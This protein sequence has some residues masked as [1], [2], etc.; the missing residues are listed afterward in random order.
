MRRTARRVGLAAGGLAAVLAAAPAAAQEAAVTPVPPRVA[1]VVGNADYATVSDLPNAARDA[2]DMAALLRLFGFEVFEGRDLDRRGF[3]TFLRE[4]LLNLPEGAEVVFFYAGH[5]I[6]IGARNYLLPTD[7]A[8]AS[9]NDLPLYS[10]TLDRVVEAL[11]ARGSVHVVFVDACRSNPFPGLS[12][13]TGLAADIAETRSGF[14][15]FPAPINSL[16]AFSTSP[17]QTA[18]DGPAGQNS[19]YTAALLAAV[20]AAPQDDVASL[21]PRI[22]EQVYAATGGAQVPWESSTLV[23][24]FQ[25]A[26][27]GMTALP[28]LV[29][30]DVP[31]TPERGADLPP[32]VEV[33]ARAPLDRIVDLAPALAA[34]RAPSLA[35]GTVV[36]PP[37]SGEVA[38]T[39]EGGLFY[40]PT[41]RETPAVGLDAFVLRDSFTLEV[42]PAEATR[43]VTVSVEL[44]AD[45]CDLAAGDALDLGGVGL[46]RLPNQIDPAAAIPACTAAL[47]ARPDSARFRYQLGRAQLAAG[48]FVPA[49]ESFRAAGAAG[50]VRAW[51]AEAGLLLTGRLD[52]SLVPIP[53]DEV[54]ATE[55][56]EQGIAE[57]DPFAIH[58]RGLRLLR[59]GTTA[60]ARQRGFELLDR[61]AELGHTYSMNELGIYFLTKDSDHYQP[62]RGMTYLRASYER[63]DIYGM[64]NLGF[65]VLYGLDGQAPDPARA[66][67]FFEAAAAGGH[68]KSPATL[69]RMVMRGELGPIDAP[70]AVAWYDMGLSRGDGWGGA[71]AAGII[72]QGGVPGLGPAD[73]AARAAKAALLPD[74][75]AAAAARALLDG[76]DRRALDGGLQTILAELGDP[77]AV[78][79][80]AGPATR[81]ALA[82]RV[83]AAGLVPAGDSPADRLM[84]AAR[85]YWLARP[86]RPDLY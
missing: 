7:A 4:V 33:A 59:E 20:T 45:A 86:V 64:H 61:A 52:R 82:A 53:K 60:E 28:T 24:P 30:A 58:S 15:A 16:V 38:M 48:D 80:E 71:N 31:A 9:V 19:P 39:A 55:L 44:E 67:P 74:A 42:G 56:L 26:Q 75:E 5:G 32:P 50:H 79:G 1:L 76:L 2:A 54:R 65:V 37:A 72:L 35:G 85:L 73:A 3:E 40:R 29:E 11:A 17:G 69:G 62:E 63:D 66:A 70:K 10:V 13:T 27:P 6:Q 83:A 14:V 23:R 36:A 84:T 68:P 12:L 8:F 21:L 46:Y 78:D 51:Q 43:L 47:T 22:R 81:A 77:L 49:L 18:V 41:L 25:F 34:A 57:G